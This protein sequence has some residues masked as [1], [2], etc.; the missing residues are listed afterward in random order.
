MTDADRTLDLLAGDAPDLFGEADASDEE[1]RG[2]LAMGVEPRDCRNAIGVRPCPFVGCSSHLLLDHIHTPHH[3]EPSLALSRARLPMFREPDAL[4]VRGRRRELPPSLPI[5]HPVVHSFIAAAVE[6][7]WE[8]PDTCAREVA[9]RGP[10]ELRQLAVVM[11]AEEDEIGIDQ[12]DAECALKGAAI[13][14]GADPED[15]EEMTTAV[16]ELLTR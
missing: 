15:A 12:D 9:A 2:W 7:L 13:V 11:G 8:M 10:H 6:R 14:A 3:P 16:L 1:H 4:P 5:G